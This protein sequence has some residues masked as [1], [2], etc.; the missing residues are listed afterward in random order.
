MA[1]SSAIKI[2][3]EEQ[4]DKLKRKFAV[5]TKS[6]F[7]FNAENKDGMIE[8]LQIKLG[9]TREEILAIISSL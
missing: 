7:L 9:K 4:K 5:L 8:R 3:W 2:S 6:D 1:G